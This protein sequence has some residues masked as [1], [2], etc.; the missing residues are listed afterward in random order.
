MIGFRSIHN[1]LTFVFTF[2]GLAVVLFIPSF[3][4]IGWSLILTGLI[5]YFISSFE[6]AKEYLDIISLHNESIEISELRL[7]KLNVKLDK[8]I[9]LNDV[10]KDIDFLKM[11][12]II[13]NKIKVFYILATKSNVG[14]LSLASKDKDL[15]FE[16]KIYKNMIRK[17][18]VLEDT[19]GG[20]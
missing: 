12:V 19:K 20:F 17:I 13:D 2:V 11:K 4:N 15:T 16:I 1:I 14:K 8:F 5:S 10:V 6:D 18:E 7:E 3:G 9:V